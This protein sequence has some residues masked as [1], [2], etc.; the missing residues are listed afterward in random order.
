MSEQNENQELQS[1]VCPECHGDQTRK[2]QMKDKGVYL[3]LGILSMTF[4]ALFRRI[5]S[6]EPTLLVDLIGVGL[7][8]F[9]LH[10]MHKQL[11]SQYEYFFCSQCKTRFSP[12]HPELKSEMIKKDLRNSGIMIGFGL[13]IGV[14]ISSIVMHLLQR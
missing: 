9:V 4:Y 3:G 1:V 14:L 7:T 12:K 11:P 10:T 6:P 2:L 13:V 8:W 5:V